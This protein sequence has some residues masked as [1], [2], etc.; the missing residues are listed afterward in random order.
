MSRS[1][2][3]ILGLLAASVTIL[4]AVTVSPVQAKDLFY[5]TV[6]GGGAATELIAIHVE[7]VNRTTTTLVGATNGGDCISLALSTWGTLYSMCGDLFGV[8]KLATIDQGDGHAT[9]FGMGVSGRAVMSLAF[10][11]E[12]TLY[13]VGN[14]NPGPTECTPGPLT[15]NS[16]YKVDVTTG[17]FTLI[18]PTGATLFFMDLAFDRGGNMYGVTATLNPSGGPLSTLYRINVA[19]GAATKVVDL[20]GST[21]IMGLSF[22]REKNKLYATDFYSINSALYLVDIKTGFLTPVATTGYGYSS[23]LV[24][25]PESH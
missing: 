22:D 10:A 1:T 24:S 7:N 15:Y 5:T 21:S 16:L 6:G 20:V 9:V 25:V 4:C 11:P 14:C 8:Q 13:A 23:N 18:G 17:L 2:K 3:G 19:T 12:G